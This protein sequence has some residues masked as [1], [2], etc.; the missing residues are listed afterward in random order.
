MYKQ[1]V[2]LWNQKQIQFI[3]NQC[4][5]NQKLYLFNFLV[6]RVYLKN[7]MKKRKLCI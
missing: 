2:S 7:G 5:L 4:G 3:L 1:D 6:E